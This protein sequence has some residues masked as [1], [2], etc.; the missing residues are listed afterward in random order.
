MRPTPTRP[1]E[2]LDASSRPLPAPRRV[3][4]FGSA[5]FIGA[6]VGEALER[7][8]QAVVRIPHSAVDLCD[9]DAVADA[10]GPG[11][12]VINAAGYANATD[13]SAEGMGRFERSNV[14][15][16]RN[17]AET[18]VSVGIAQL[19]H[20]SSVAAMGRVFGEHVKE[21]ARGPVTSS[22]ASSKRK[23]EEILAE[24]TSRMPITVLRPTSV[25]GE[26]RGLASVLCR[27]ST[28][29]LVPLPAGGRALIP[30]TYV[31][32]VAHGIALSVGNTACFGGTFTIGDAQS[33]PL[34]EIV[35]ELAMAM[36]RRPHVLDV[37]R[38]LAMFGVASAQRIAAVLGRPP[39]LDSTRLETMVT[40]VS[41]S[42]DHF[43]G[44]TGF[45]PPVPL[46]DAAAGI[47]HWYL[48]ERSN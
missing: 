35:M 32:N 41:Y 45:Q 29:P 6:H 8:G 2:S 14:T 38:W 47:A 16:V 30:F 3:V 31:G 27:A 13:R 39:L 24:Y 28:L 46:H 44:A 15:A 36:G 4:L 25:F 42:I 17:L 1:T 37:P 22:Y 23:G 18:S 10:L 40:S 11:D 26:G 19:I 43:V 48:S 5:G 9:A 7:R 20:V 33:Y 12:I 21:G 34:R